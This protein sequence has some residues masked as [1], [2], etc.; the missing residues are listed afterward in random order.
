MERKREFKTES[1]K[2]L[3]MMIHSIYTHKEI[4][5]REL[6]SNAS[7]AMDKLHFE[8]LTN[9]ELKKNAKEFKIEIILDKGKR[10]FAIAD[11]GIGMTLEELESNL[12][13]IAKSGSLEFK[14]QIE[15][16][17]EEID[18]IG[19]FGVGFYSSF[20][21]AK[22]ITVL[23]KSPKSEK[24]YK[25]VSEGEEGYIISECDIQENG[26]IITLDLRDNTEDDDYDE[27]LDTYTIKRLIKKYSD[28][29]R[30]PIHMEVEKSVPKKDE[31]GQVI[32]GEYETI[33]EDEIVNSM[34]PIWKK[35]KNDISKEEYNDFYMSKF[36]DWMEPLKVIH[37]NVEGV[38]SFKSIMYIPSSTPYNFYTADYEK[39]LQLYSKGVFIMDKASELIPEYF[40]FVKGLVDSDDLSLNISRE[41]LQQ[42]KQV[43][44]IAKNIESKI[45]SELTKMLET[46]FE[47]YTQFF[48]NFGRQIKYGIYDKF[49]ANKDTLQDLILFKSTLNK[50]Y[51]TLKAY[52]ERMKEGQEFIYFASGDSIEQIDKL[53]QM[54]KIRDLGYEV[55]YF[56]D[57][58]D[59]F[60]VMSMMTYQ[61]KA[62]RSVNQGDL[63]L[64]SEEDKKEL[65]KKSEE[66]KDLLATL[67]DALE[68]KV[69]EVKLSARLKSHPVCL[70]STEGVSF[71]MEKVISQMPGNDSGIK[72]GRILEI[73]PDHKIFKTLQRL[74][75]EDKEILKEYADLLYSQALLIEGFTLEDPLDFS[76]KITEIMSRI[77]S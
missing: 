28:Y 69:V 12:G 68:G 6:I 26:T 70:V 16:K 10:Q 36:G 11:A 51:V 44:I 31:K 40:R 15:D 52:V 34:I 65:E 1:K 14:Q 55:L 71:E 22:K 73:N 33:Q 72:A 46:D 50:E 7:D 56:T 3:D 74:Y 77:Q 58:V 5:L 41:I 62:F 13:T 23:T 4:F 27:Y 19:Q 38:V 43:K 57:D 63:G 17:S 30:Y 45:K 32:E 18:I 61:E 64:D 35:N 8:S 66:S 9:Q 21:V 54:E 49:G 59:E 42:N 37:Y 25:W 53:P 2:L 29:I 24:G 48:D 47:N 20:M 67:K 39:G 60:A 76:N 75:E